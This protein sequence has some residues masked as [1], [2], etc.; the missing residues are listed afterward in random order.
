MIKIASQ[1]RALCLSTVVFCLDAPAQNSDP[2]GLLT[3]WLNAQT[4]IQTWSADFTQ[5]RRLKAL[6]QPLTATGHVYFAAPNLFRWEIKKPTSTMAIRQSDT[7][8]VLYPR[9]K[10]AEKYPL[11]SANSGP[12][13]DT[14]ALLDAGFPRSRAEVESRFNIISQNTRDDVHEIALQ[15]KVPTARKFMPEIRIGF[16][17]RN[18]SLRETV[19]VFADGSTMENIFTNAQMNPKIDESL[20][21]PDLN[22]YKISEP[23]SK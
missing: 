4:N 1:I 20:F 22:G 16:D 8:Y 19:L 13:K 6:T 5:T 18:F 12:W 9:L 17:I 23:F 15:P 14:L 2:N 11:D 3:S 7:L 21:N 10:R